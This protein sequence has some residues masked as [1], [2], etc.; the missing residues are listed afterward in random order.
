MRFRILV[1]GLLFSVATIAVSQSVPGQSKDI[2]ESI[3][4]YLSV[5]TE[6]GRFSGAILV[7]RNGAIILRQGYGFADVEKQIPYTPDTQ[8]EVASISKMFTAM[9]ALKLQ[10]QGKLRLDEPVCKYLD[11]C[12]EAWKPVTIQQLIRH[13]SGIPDYEEKLELGS[14]NYLGFM[15]QPNTSARIVEN[16]KKQA[17]DF[18]PGEKFHYSNTGYIVLGYVL[19]KAADMPFSEYIEK[20]LLQPA[21]MKRSGVLGT[22][23]APKS[24]ATGYTFGDIGWEKTLAGYPLTAGHLKKMP[25]L[26][27]TPPAG[28]AWLYSTVD[29]L[30]RWSQAMEGNGVI[31][32]AAINE[33]FT[34]GLGNYGYGWFIDNGFGRKRTRHNGMLPGYTSDFIRFPDE[35]ITII[36]F[37]NL[38]RA[39]LSRI[40]R[41]VTAIVLGTPYD[42]PVRGKV[43]SLTEPQIAQLVGDYKTTDG[44]V[45][46]IRKEPEF[47]I[48]SIKGRYNAGLIPLS[49]TEFYFPLADGKAIFTVENGRAKKVNMRYSGE[50]H[51]AERVE[52]RP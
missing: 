12:P 29:D 30:Y 7:A 38:D 13:T 28:D 14:D 36:I 23:D 10:E 34:A 45:L 25:R 39:P 43:I 31:T 1:L 42:M 41:D 9:A 37:S 35:K 2:G 46:T 22:K 47:L 19:Q 48:A 18:K 16:A 26:E 32:A 3:N 24:L 40:M 50:D 51:L 17:L 11:D 21:G 27:L 20:N 52:P 4:E 33:T 49:P 15:T 6:M 8:H 44:Q 5:R